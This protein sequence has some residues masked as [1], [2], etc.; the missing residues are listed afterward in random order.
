MISKI[1]NMAEKMQDS[2]DR[3]LESLFHSGAIADNGFSDR[4]VAR[5]RRQTWVRRLTL[6]VAL[7]LGA[8]IALKPATQLIAVGSQIY[9]SLSTESMV[10]QS[11]SATQLPVFAMVGAALAI[12]VLM[13]RLSEE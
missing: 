11:V 13:F 3:A 2:E 5:I 6:P 7:I 10:L 1:I 8:T 4:V 12:A 9:G